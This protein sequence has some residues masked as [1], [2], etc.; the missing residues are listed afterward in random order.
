MFL[1]LFLLTKISSGVYAF[2]PMEKLRQKCVNVCG[3]WRQSAGENHFH[4][5]TSVYPPFP[6]F[7]SGKK[8]VTE[9]T[10]KMRQ[11][12]TKLQRRS[13]YE[14]WSR[15]TIWQGVM[16]CVCVRAC[17]MQPFLNLVTA[18]TQNIFYH[19]TAL[20]HLPCNYLCDA[21]C[22]LFLNLTLK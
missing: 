6:P 11:Q 1:S 13:K 9:R 22:G 3:Q 4:T 20:V 14:M 8:C 19:W 21:Y 18:G 2:P 5:P 12:R 16:R 15:V 10:Q 17:P 7:L